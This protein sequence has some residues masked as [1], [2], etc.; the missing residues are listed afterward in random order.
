MVVC[1]K[2]EWVKCIDLRPN[3]DDHLRF[4]RDRL[5]FLIG[6]LTI[7]SF[8]GKHERS[9]LIINFARTENYVRAECFTNFTEMLDFDGIWIEYEPLANSF[10][11]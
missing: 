3:A 1:L 6:G 2:A 10:L 11:T 7:Q 8:G 4:G 5:H 9:V